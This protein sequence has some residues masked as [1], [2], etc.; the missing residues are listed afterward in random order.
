VDGATLAAVVTETGSHA[1]RVVVADDQAAVREGL[2]TLLDLLPDV[3]VVGAAA[4]GDGAVS[5]VERF[6]PDVVLMDLRMPKVDGLEA[7]RRIRAGNTTTQIVVLTTY[8]DDRSILDAL[9]AGALGYLTKDAGRDDIARALHSA[10]AGQAVLDPAAHARVLAATA[11]STPGI[12]PHDEGP[13]SKAPPPPATLTSREAE[14]LRLI[15]AG[16]SNPAIAKRLFISENTVKSHVNHLFAKI[17]AIDRAQ[18]VA[19]AYENGMVGSHR[20]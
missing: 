11:D 19:Y 4:D 20:P 6:R 3:T 9:H 1:L 16:L 2:V 12:W 10:A 14:V 8:A 15:A 18:A 5:L 13:Q 17:G 7:I